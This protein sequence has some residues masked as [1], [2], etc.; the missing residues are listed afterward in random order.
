MIKPSLSTFLISSIIFVHASAN[1][2]I[3]TVDSTKELYAAIEV[4]NQSRSKT[5]I[6]LAPQVYQITSRIKLAGDHI[7]LIGDPISPLNV[8]FNGRGMVSR[9]EVEVL[10]D[11]SG[12][13]IYINGIT[14]R[15]SANHLIQVRGEQNASSFFLHNSILQDSYE[16]MLKV[17]GGNEIE[18]TKASNGKVI[19]CLFEYTEDVGPQ[20]YIGG[21]DAHWA[22]GWIVKNNKF[23]NIASPAKRVAEHAI[24]F[25]NHSSDNHIIGNTIIDSDRGIGFGL[26]NSSHQNLGGIIE[27]NLIIHTNREHPFADSGIVLE[28]SPMTIVR[29]NTIILLSGY[30]NA[31]EYRFKPTTSV[32]IYKN[33]VNRKIKARNGAVA[34]VSENLFINTD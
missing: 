2:Q 10:V 3:F 25:W 28:S 31:I 27:N 18:G 30:P 24:H 1:E 22:N 11:V 19:N 33:T 32:K 21:I 20:Y 16:Q 7:S 15:N 6:H 13:G 26:G 34:D 4:A 23:R 14:I 8:V 12:K 29:N 9:K 5:T 17:T